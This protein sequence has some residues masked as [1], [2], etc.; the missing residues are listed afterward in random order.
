MFCYVF[1]MLVLSSQ[2][3]VFGCEATAIRKLFVINLIVMSMFDLF[4][5]TNVASTLKYVSLRMAF[6]MKFA[7]YAYLGYGSFLLQSCDM[8]DCVFQRSSSILLSSPI[9]A[10]L[11]FGKLL[12]GTVMLVFTSTYFDI[13]LFVD[14]VIFAMKVFGCEAFAIRTLFVMV[15]CHDYGCYIFFVMKVGLSF[16]MCSLRIAFA[17]KLVRYGCY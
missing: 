12:F 6:A 17:M 3:N 2:Y 4:A 7:R 5:V 15:A 13:V 9:L 10:R 1:S 11:P 8:F 14:D 16:E